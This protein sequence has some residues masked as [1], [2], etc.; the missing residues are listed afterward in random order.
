MENKERA[1]LRNALQDSIDDA[2]VAIKHLERSKTFYQKYPSRS[3]HVTLVRINVMI[4]Q[5]R[6]QIAKTMDLMNNLTKQ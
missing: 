5:Y 1:E 4:G 2:N 6:S 3:N